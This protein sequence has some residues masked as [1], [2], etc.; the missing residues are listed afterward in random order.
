MR[1][2]TSFV[3]REF[4]STR[5]SSRKDDVRKGEKGIT[6]TSDSDCSCNHGVALS[7][8]ADLRKCNAKG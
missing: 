7:A 5:S 3:V 1:V 2:V 4:Q 8:S 6:F